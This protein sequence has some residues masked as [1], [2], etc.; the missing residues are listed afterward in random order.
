M[1]ALQNTQLRQL[2]DALDTALSALV[3]ALAL[4]DSLD[5]AE[6]SRVVANLTAALAT[7][8]ATK[9]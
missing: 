6:L 3:R 5:A 8:E 2:E 4:D 7:N 9:R 1:A